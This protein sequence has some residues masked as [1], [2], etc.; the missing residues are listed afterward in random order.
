MQPEGPPKPPPLVH[1]W[2]PDSV[3]RNEPT[4]PAP[5]TPAAEN[6]HSGIRSPL[7]MRKSSHERQI[8]GSP[9]MKQ[10]GGEFSLYLLE[11]LKKSNCYKV[12]FLSCKF[13]GGLTENLGVI[14]QMKRYFLAE[15]DSPR[16]KTLI[17]IL[18]CSCKLLTEVSCL[19]LRSQILDLLVTV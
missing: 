12:F 18:I 3:A 13:V 11:G 19:T 1:S 7:Q 15:N 17:G 4:T 5:W 2:W 9:E 10:D 8:S 16:P 6:T 14:L